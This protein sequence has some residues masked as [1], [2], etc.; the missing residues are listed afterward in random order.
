MRMMTRLII[1]LLM[2]LVMVPFVIVGFVIRLM[3][4][5]LRGG[6][7]EYDRFIAWLESLDKEKDNASHS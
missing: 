6:W 7:H 2:M 1:A 4:S 5:G 3:L